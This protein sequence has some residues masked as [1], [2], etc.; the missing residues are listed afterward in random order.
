MTTT[1]KAYIMNVSKTTCLFISQ[2]DSN[3]ISSTVDQHSY[4]C[5]AINLVFASVYSCL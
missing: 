1:A 3:A 5:T 2:D 4:R